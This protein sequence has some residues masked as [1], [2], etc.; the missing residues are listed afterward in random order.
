MHPDDVP[1]KYP[2]EHEH[3]DCA[4]RETVKADPRKAGQSFKDGMMKFYPGR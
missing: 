4:K 1:S 2:C 3:V